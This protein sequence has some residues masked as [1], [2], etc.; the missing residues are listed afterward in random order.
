MTGK[1]TPKSQD[2]ANLQKDPLLLLGA[3]C[4]GISAA[5]PGG[6]LLTLLAADKKGGRRFRKDRLPRLSGLAVIAL[7]PA[8]NSRIF[9]GP[10]PKSLF[11]P[12]SPQQQPSAS[13]GLVVLLRMNRHLDSA[14]KHHEWLCSQ[15]R[16]LIQLIYSLLR[17]VLVVLSKQSSRVQFP[18]QI[19]LPYNRACGTVKKRTSSRFILLKVHR[20]LFYVGSTAGKCGIDRYR[21]NAAL[22][23]VF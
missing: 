17:M 13:A 20:L 16:A 18:S 11:S 10:V 23:L 12:E 7:N 1:K 15:Q 21:G 8:G 2:A 14:I 9:D 6:R 19:G 3:C 5:V 22:P 4:V